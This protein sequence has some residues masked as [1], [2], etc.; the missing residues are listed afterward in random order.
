MKKFEKKTP[1]EA[2]DGRYVAWPDPR[3]R[4]EVG[5]SAEPP[6]LQLPIKRITTTTFAYVHRNFVFTCLISNFTLRLKSCSLHLRY[7]V[8]Y[9]KSKHSQI[10]TYKNNSMKIDLYSIL[11]SDIYSKHRL[12]TLYLLIPNPKG[13]HH[14]HSASI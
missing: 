5:R 6:S 7:A 10:I 11:H 9:I 2:S 8:S 4:H 13:E 12:N 1:R 14:A 3:R